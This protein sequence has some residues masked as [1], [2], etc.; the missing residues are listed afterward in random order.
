[1]RR[2][3]LIAGLVF[4]AGCDSSLF[5]AHADVAA[6]AADQELSSERLAAIMSNTKGMRLTPEAAELV[7]NIWVDYAL[8]A[9]AVASGELPMDSIAVSRAMWAQIAEI[10]QARWFDSLIERSSSFSPESADSVYAA[11]SVRVLQHI[12]F[13]VAP[14]AEPPVR[15]EA[16]S[17]ANEALAQVRSGEDFSALAMKLSDDPMSARD[18]G[19]LPP[20]PRGAFVTAFDSAGWRLG[21]GEVSG[22]VETPFGYHIIKRPAP[23]EVR[24]RLIA[25]QQSGLVQKIDSIYRDSLAAANNLDVSGDAAALVRSAIEDP[26]GA[27][28]SSSELA[29]WDGGEFTQADLMKWVYAMPPQALAGIEGVPDEQLAM[30]AR[31]LAQNE[32]L[33]AE[34]EAAGVGLTPL[35]WQTLQ[36][37]YRAELDTLKVLLGLGYDVTDTTLVRDERSKVAALKLNQYFDG[38][39]AGTSIVRKVPASLSL[40]LR[41]E[42][43]WEI[44]QAGLAHALELA[45]DSTSGDSTAAPPGTLTPAPGQPPIGPQ[46]DSAP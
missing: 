5:Q 45:Q 42:F 9:Q 10:R 6:E 39:M 25:F 15:E 1:M 40:M 13:R 38:V 34:A 8:F 36:Q 7:A 17:K 26:E 3:W 29:T 16:R 12:L 27:I 14:N 31:Y 30:F 20:S 43:E 37:G 46:S 22:I 41:E 19:Y 44:Y 11:D 28:L 2:V 4:L 33:L 18:S 21:P 32:I 35:E 24:D 23:G